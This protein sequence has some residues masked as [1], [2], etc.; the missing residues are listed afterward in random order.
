MEQ[1][2]KETPSE[3]R[4]RKLNVYKRFYLK[5]ELIWA[6]P[7]D[8]RDYEVCTV[9]RKTQVLQVIS[10]THRGNNHYFELCEDCFEMYGLKFISGREA[11][12]KYNLL[13]KLTRTHMYLGKDMC[14]YCENKR[15]YMVQVEFSEPKVPSLEICS[16]CARKLGISYER[17]SL[18]EM[19]YAGT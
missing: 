8:R 14:Q 1:M 6:P 12:E 18:S 17:R 3:Y 13:A 15:Q 5:Q 11:F 2:V 7:Y 16:G 9:C 10:F 4:A 19:G